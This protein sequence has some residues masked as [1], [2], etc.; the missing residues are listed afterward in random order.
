M[1]SHR[2]ASIGYL[3][4][5]TMCTNTAALHHG[6]WLWQIAPTSSISFTCVQTSS[7]IGGGSFRATIWRVCH[8]WPWSHALPCLYNPALLVQGKRCHDTQPTGLRQLLGFSQT[9][10]LSQID[11]A[12]GRESPSSIQLTSLL[13][14]YPG[15]CL[16]SPEFWVS[17]SLGAQHSWLLL[18]WL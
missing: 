5:V 12:V 8:Q 3:M 6:L 10:L 9:T 11:P 4:V 18:G 2:S 17:I 7:T 14:G 1:I 16:V 15:S 13:V